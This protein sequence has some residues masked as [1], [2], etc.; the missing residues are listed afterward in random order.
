MKKAVLTLVFLSVCFISFAQSQPKV[1]DVLEVKAPKGEHYN[2]IDFPRLNILVKRGKL[3]SYKPV[4]NTIVLI[5][6]VVAKENK[7]YVVLKKKDGTK[8][9]GLQTTVEAD[10]QKALDSGELTKVNP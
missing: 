9:F 5:D 6:D 1:G 7:T 8:F 10:Y 3:A 2:H 4:I